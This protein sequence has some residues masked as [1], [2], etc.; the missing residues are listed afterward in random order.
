MV[1]LV[2]L[3]SYRTVLERPIALVTICI[4]VSS[5]TVLAQ[6]FLGHLHIAH[7]GHCSLCKYVTL[8]VIHN[9]LPMKST[10]FNFRVV[11]YSRKN[12]QSYTWIMSDTKFWHDI[13]VSTFAILVVRS[14]KTS[15]RKKLSDICLARCAKLRILI[16]KSCNFT[17]QKR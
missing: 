1:L 9:N 2:S 16:L 14:T 3:T 12:G 8:R 10:D 7:A 5:R 11:I 13:L 6:S 15:Y 4:R 17:A